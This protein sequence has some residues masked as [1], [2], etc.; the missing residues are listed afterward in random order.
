MNRKIK[1]KPINHRIGNK[2]NIL[3]RRYSALSWFIHCSFY[4]GVSWFYMFIFPMNSSFYPI[5]FQK[6]PGNILTEFLHAFIL[7]LI[8]LSAPLL[9]VWLI[10]LVFIIIFG[11]TG[12]TLLIKK[13]IFRNNNF[14]Y[15]KVIKK[16]SFIHFLILSIIHLI[17]LIPFIGWFLGAIYFT[18]KYVLKKNIY[19]F[20][21][22]DIKLKNKKYSIK[23]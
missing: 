8:Y 5:I 15:N 21:I 2:N 19:F 14:N 18:L 20:E 12:V 9:F 4:A 10:N 13:I 1:N 23:Y 17:F 11:D 6:I 3:S 22:Y 7:S 16:S